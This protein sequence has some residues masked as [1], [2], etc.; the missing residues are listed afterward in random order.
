MIETGLIRQFFAFQIS[1]SK[2]RLDW[3][4]ATPDWVGI[5][6]ARVVDGGDEEVIAAVHHAETFEDEGAPLG[7]LNRRI[8]YRL[9]LDGA[10]APAAETVLN[11]TR[12]SGEAYL[13]AKAQRIQLKKR[14]FPVALFAVKSAGLRCVC[15]DVTRHEVSVESCPKC[16]GTG[17]RTGYADPVVIPML[18]ESLEQRNSSVGEGGEI[19]ISER[20]LWTSVEF[21]VR[22]R[23]VLV[24]A[25]NN[26][27]RVEGLSQSAIGESP[28]KQTV[29]CMEISPSNVEFDLQIPDA[30]RIQLQRQ[31]DRARLL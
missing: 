5:R 11:A 22:S 12:I 17:F 24:T 29:R 19:E 25:S 2:V 8:L 7:S 20:T 27:Y 1:R 16:N 10:D 14:G 28:L 23:D 6:V 30:I 26:R 15:F 9:Y 18:G 4:L 3:E 31:P 21:R 13:F